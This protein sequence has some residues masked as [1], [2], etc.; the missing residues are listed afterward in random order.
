M[1]LKEI[2][3]RKIVMKDTGMDEFVR[4]KYRFGKLLGQGAS[5]SVFE[6]THLRTKSKCA[7][8][9]R[10]SRRTDV[11][12]RRAPQWRGRS[13]HCGRAARHR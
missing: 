9:V 4:G 12:G 3:R 1:L 13:A 8:K 5:A 7:I 11:P 10:P 2:E 6:A